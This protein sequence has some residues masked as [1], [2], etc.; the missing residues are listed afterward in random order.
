MDYLNK[1]PEEF[2][3]NHQET[4][5]VADLLLQQWVSRFDT[6]PADL[7]RWRDETYLFFI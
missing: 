3:V 6:N 5:M 1:W 2:S 4:S 7:F